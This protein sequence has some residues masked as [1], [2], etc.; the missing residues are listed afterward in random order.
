MQKF[1]CRGQDQA[2]DAAQDFPES[3]KNRPQKLPHRPFPYHS[4]DD[5]PRHIPQPQVRIADRKPL[6]KPGE[7]STDE[8]QHIPQQR[9]PWPQWTQEA[10]QEPQSHPKQR[11]DAEPADCQ[12]RGRHPKSLLTQLPVCRASS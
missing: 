3:G 8:E 2:G 10:I 1:F 4:A 5:Q 6:I 9:V 12:R 11:T 7:K